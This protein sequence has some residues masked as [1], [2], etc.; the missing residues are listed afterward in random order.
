MLFGQFDN[1]QRREKSV[2]G[3]REKLLKGEWVTKAPIG[4][5]HVLR[6]GQKLIV[7]NEIGKLIRKA[8]EW[9]ANEESNEIST[10]SNH[11]GKDEYDSSTGKCIIEYNEK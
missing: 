4:Y 9:K 11:F 8:F 1:D 2:A 10:R 7:V 6:S 3:S 5:D